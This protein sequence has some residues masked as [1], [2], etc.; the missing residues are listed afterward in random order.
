MLIDK[1][2][3]FIIRRVTLE[4]A[5]YNLEALGGFQVFYMP[6]NLYDVLLY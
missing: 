3:C 1:K 5:K 6:N 2:M 4:E